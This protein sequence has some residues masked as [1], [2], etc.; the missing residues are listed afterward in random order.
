VN[1]PDPTTTLNNPPIEA[2]RAACTHLHG[3][4]D[5]RCDYD[6][7]R[8]GLRSPCLSAIVH[9]HTL[10]ELARLRALVVEAPPLCED[11]AFLSDLL[12]RVEA[13]ETVTLEDVTRLRRL[14][15]WAD[16]PPAPG[17]NGTLDIEEARRGVAD[18]RRRLAL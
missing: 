8:S 2:V 5:C 12:A 18:A 14:A 17:W 3:G 1:R 9:A 16:A 13:R 4:T 11:L 15:D 6:G 7:R 10:A